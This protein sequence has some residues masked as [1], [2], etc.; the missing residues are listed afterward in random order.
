MFYSTCLINYCLEILAPAGVPPAVVSFG[1]CLP[2]LKVS[3][4]FAP[5]GLTR[6]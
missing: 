1:A 3:G 2:V 6:M 5:G 4:T